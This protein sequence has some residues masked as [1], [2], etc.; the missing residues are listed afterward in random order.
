MLKTEGRE[1]YSITCG[2]LRVKI[3]VFGEFS[4]VWIERMKG[5]TWNRIRRLRKSEIQLA[6]SL[7]VDADQFVNAVSEDL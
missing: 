1:K 4:C 7:L 3:E 6:A 2:T 5:D